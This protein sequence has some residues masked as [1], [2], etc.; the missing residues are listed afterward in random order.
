[1]IYLSGSTNDTIED[2]LIESGVGLMLNLGTGYASRVGRYPHW[3]VDNGAFS[4]KW[5]ALTWAEALAGIEPDER[6][7]F[8]VAPDVYGDA[9]AS[10]T[11]GLQYAEGMR[12]T[13]WP[14]AVVAQDGAEH[15][16]W[17]WDEFDVLFLGGIRGLVE[18]KESLGAE[19]LA[20][21]ALS[22]G[23]SVHMGRVNTLQRMKRARLM[24][25]HSVDGTY[26]AF[27]PDRNVVRLDRFL[28]VLANTPP[29]PLEALEAENA[30]LTEAL[31]EL[32]DA[33]TGDLGHIVIPDALATMED[34]SKS[35][36]AALARETEGTDG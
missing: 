11:L 32:V 12:A 8:A 20:R 7:L 10:L 14:V 23:K 22:H 2:R 31:T 33:Y 27:G 25:C 18:W 35:A 1:M 29:L 24:G 5:D 16:R 19:W 6:C 36:R 9:G 26:I 15:L 30:R 3:A 34:A 21:Q 28:R 4:D 13:G 17:P